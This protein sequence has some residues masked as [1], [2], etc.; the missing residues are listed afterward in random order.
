MYIFC[1]TLLINVDEKYAV[2]EVY[3][4]CNG[5]KYDISANYSYM[6]AVSGFSDIT[7]YIWTKI[8][9]LLWGYERVKI[10]ES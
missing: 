7:I 8:L 9:M 10:K 4:Y 2:K 3:A 6:Y 1:K 5:E